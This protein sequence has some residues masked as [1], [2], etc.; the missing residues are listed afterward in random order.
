MESAK[1]SATESSFLFVV[2]VLSVWHQ[3]KKIEGKNKRLETKL[4]KKHALINVSIRLKLC[5]RKEA[6]TVNYW[7]K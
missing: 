1:V 4:G 6:E 3:E 2:F 7:L 5:R